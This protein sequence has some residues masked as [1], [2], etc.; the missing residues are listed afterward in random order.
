VQRLVLAVILGVIALIL[1]RN[2]SIIEDFDIYGF[3]VNGEILKKA[4]YV[5]IGFAPST[6][7]ALIKKK[8][9]SKMGVKS[10]PANR[11]MTVDPDKKEKPDGKG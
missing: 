4:L 7:M 8:V 1:V 6:V 11:T 2:F 10:S 3:K 5:I 9:E